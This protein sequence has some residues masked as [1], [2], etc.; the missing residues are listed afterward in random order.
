MSVTAPPSHDLEESPSPAA[1]SLATVTAAGQGGAQAPVSPSASTGEALESIDKTLA[2]DL[3][4]LL[5]GD[6]LAVEQV[7]DGVFEDF[8]AIV[9]GHDDGPVRVQSPQSGRREAKARR[10]EPSTGPVEQALGAAAAA[11]PAAVPEEPEPALVEPTHAQLHT[12]TETAPS[13]RATAAPDRPVASSPIA[14]QPLP[15]DSEL[16]RRPMALLATVARAGVRITVT[17]LA[18]MNEPLRRLPRSAQ[19]LINPIAISLAIWVPI[20]WMLGQAISSKNA[21]G[22]AASS[23]ESADDSH[24]SAAKPAAQHE[25]PAATPAHGGEH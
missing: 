22:P 13:A 9:Q 18:A 2:N 12:E 5:D 14:A 1:P 7:L 11:E 10:G 23:H 19:P 25:K 15:A 6:F 20:T 24:S 17:L 3:D 21:A 16:L 4:T 8:A